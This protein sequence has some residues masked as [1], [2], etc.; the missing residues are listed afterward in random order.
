VSTRGRRDGVLP[1]TDLFGEPVERPVPERGPYYATNDI[2]VIEEVLRKA[3]SDLGYV[4]IGVSEQVYRL[5]DS[6]RV[7]RVPI[8]EEDVV[9]QLLSESLLSVGGRRTID[10]G[11]FDCV[12]NTVAVPLATR[13]MLSRWRALAPHGMSGRYG[14]TDKPSTEGTHGAVTTGHE[15]DA[16]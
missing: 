4:L 14:V 15:R 9:H 2:A 12:A 13:R 7:E 3:A 10:F 5:V 6:D 8:D 1:D 11:R 16:Q